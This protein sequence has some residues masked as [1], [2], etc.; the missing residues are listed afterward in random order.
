MDEN[1]EVRNSAF[2][3]SKVVDL[4]TQMKVLSFDNA[5]LVKQNEELRARVKSLATRHP[6]WPGGYRPTRKQN[7]DK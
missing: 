1:T 3:E 2:F 5:E 6:Q 7:H 4:E